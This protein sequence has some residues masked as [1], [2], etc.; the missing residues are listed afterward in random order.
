MCFMAEEETFGGAGYFEGL[1]S[2]KKVPNDS[3][4]KEGVCSLMAGSCAHSF[5]A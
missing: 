3:L 4:S 1:L 2:L 5:F